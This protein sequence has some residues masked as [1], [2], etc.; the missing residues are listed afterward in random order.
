[1]KGLSGH[2][3]SHVYRL[4]LARKTLISICREQSFSFDPLSLRI[5]FRFDSILYLAG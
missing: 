2:E 1:M 3:A 5:I 4:K